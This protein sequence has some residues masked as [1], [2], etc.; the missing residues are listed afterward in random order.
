TNSNL[1]SSQPCSSPQSSYCL[2]DDT[3]H[4]STPKSHVLSTGIV[5][6][7]LNKW[8]YV[9]GIPTALGAELSS[10]SLSAGQM[11]VVMNGGR[12][13]TLSVGNGARADVASGGILTSVSIASGGT[14]EVHDAGVLTGKTSVASGGTLV[15]DPA[16]AIGGSVFHLAAGAQIDLDGIDPSAVKSATIQGN[17]LTISAGS[18][19]WNLALDATWSCP[20]KLSISSDGREGSLLR[21]DTAGTAISSTVALAASAATYDTYA[22]SGGAGSIAETSLSGTTDGS[23]VHITGSAASLYYTGT[24]I[25]TTLYYN[26]SASGTSVALNVVNSAT[27]VITAFHGHSVINADGGDVHAALNDS[28]ET[29][30]TLNITVS[31]SGDGYMTLYGDTT[32]ANITANKG[33]LVLNSDK[34]GTDNVTSTGSLNVWSGSNTLDFYTLATGSD[35]ILPRFGAGLFRHHKHRYGQCRDP[36]DKRCQRKRHDNHRAAQRY[37]IFRGQHRLADLLRWVQACQHHDR[38]RCS[39]HHDGLRRAGSR[40]LRPRRTECRSEQRHEP[41]DHHGRLGR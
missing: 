11:N 25:N 21:L 40:C 15:L 6:L 26:G 31:K 13:D 32:T 27:A 8:G 22:V 9:S 12:I 3:T 29:S 39:H 5:S 33:T 37:G 1:L 2:T 18:D 16:A 28:T 10:A 41:S 20:E 38:R 19:S 23:G 34:W 24:G 30:T 17:I 4:E 14:L 36:R 7:N 35:S